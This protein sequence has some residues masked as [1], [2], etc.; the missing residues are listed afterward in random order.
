MSCQIMHNI[1]RAPAPAYHDILGIA[2]VPSGP[3]ATRSRELVELG[4]NVRLS[5]MYQ[6]FFACPAQGRV[7]IFFFRE[8]CRGAEDDYSCHQVPKILG[9]FMCQ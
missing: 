4:K 5:W 3:V 1:N 6:H 8:R 7:V 9:S 2:Y